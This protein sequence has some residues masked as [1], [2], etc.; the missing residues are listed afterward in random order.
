MIYDDDHNPVQWASVSIAGAD[1]V[2]TDIDGRFAVPSVERDTAAAALA[3]RI[4]LAALSPGTG[5]VEVLAACR[6]ARELGCAAVC[7]VPAWVETAAAALQGSGVA[8]C[9]VVGFPLGGNTTLT[10]VFE[11]LE[12]MK[13]GASEIDIVIHVGAARSGET[14]LLE[15]EAREIVKRSP[16]MLHKFILEVGLLDDNQLKR[17]VKAVASASPAFLKTGTGMA[18]PPVTPDDVRKLRSLTPSKI[19]LKASGG[20]RTHEEAVAL[21]AAGADRLGTSTPRALLP[22]V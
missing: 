4:D 20:I 1:P 6:E 21:V 15:A 22:S 13:A 2:Y 19:R 17:A 9:G 3:A 18:G 8:V 16:E 5:K 10:K 12:C 14:G 7:V 11:A